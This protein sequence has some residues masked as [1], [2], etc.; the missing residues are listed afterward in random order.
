MDDWSDT[1]CAELACQ[2]GDRITCPD[3]ADAE[4]RIQDSVVTD[5]ELKGYND[6][7]SPVEYSMSHPPDFLTRVELLAV[8][9]RDR[10]EH[11]LDIG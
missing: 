7:G 5:A 9:A 6:S 1:A 2:A 10:E 4:K 11:I 3:N 8:R